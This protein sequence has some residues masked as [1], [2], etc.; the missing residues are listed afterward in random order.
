MCAKIQQNIK[1]DLDALK[2]NLPESHI[3]LRHRNQIYLHS[4]LAG[5]QDKDI[6]CDH[7][8]LIYLP[9]KQCDLFPSQESVQL[10][11]E[12]V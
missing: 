2:S 12:G 5:N 11:L 8:L 3:S 10:P 9:F 1:C 7:Q 4:S 6:Q